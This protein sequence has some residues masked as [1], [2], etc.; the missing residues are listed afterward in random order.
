MAN[1]S[2]TLAKRLFFLIH[3]LGIR[4][5]F[6]IVPRTY[7]ATNANIIELKR[8]ISQW[9]KKSQLPGLNI[10][11]DNQLTNLKAYCLPYIRELADHAIFRGATGVYLG[12]G[13]GEQNLAATYCVLR[14]I[15]PSRV[16]EVGSGVS[17][18]GN[19]AALARNQSDT[20]RPATI[21][22]IEP[23]PTAKLR[24]LQGVSLVDK[25]V[26]SVPIETFLGLE[27]DDLLFIDSS[28]TVKPGGDVN[29]LILEVLPRLKPGV[30]V[31]FD[32]I[33]LPYDYGP[34]VLKNYYHWSE[35]SLLR[36][37]LIH[38]NKA[39]ILFSLRMLYCERLEA[40][41][42]LFPDFEPG[43]MTPQGL[44]PDRYK[45]FEYPPGNRPGAMFIRIL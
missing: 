9:A 41:I 14:T 20:G 43:E 24:S 38:N 34:T 32:D 39:E 28:H 18:Y 2:R 16:I 21:T 35:T 7:Y 12:P 23:F 26:Q 13:Y 36:A 1:Y 42:D 25:P 19:L 17:T 45:P 33:T 15:K 11:I 22:A 27:K 4:L 37:F 5:G 3:K 31:H 40:L 30:V 10:D 8:T 29:F 44:Y 6:Y